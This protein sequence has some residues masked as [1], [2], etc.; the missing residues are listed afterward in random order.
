MINMA[1][2]GV[3]YMGKGLKSREEVLY[4]SVLLA[5]AA[6]EVYPLSMIDGQLLCLNEQPTWL[7]RSIAAEDTTI[8]RF[9]PGG[10]RGIHRISAQTIELDMIFFNATS[11]MMRDEEDLKPTYDV[12]PDTIPTTQPMKYTEVGSRDTRPDGDLDR[13]RRQFLAA[14]IINGID[15]TARLWKQLKRDVVQPNYNTGHF[16]DLQPSVALRVPAQALMEHLSTSTTLDA[17]STTCFDVEDAQLFLTWLTDPRSMYYISYSI[18]RMQ[19]T[20]DGRQALMTAMYINEHFN[21]GPFEELQ[22]A[23]PTDLLDATCIPQRIWI[24]RPI[25]GGGD[26]GDVVRWRIV[27]KALLLGEPDLIEE[28]L[29]NGHRENAV[30]TLKGRTVVGG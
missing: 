5:L 28:A 2:L 4:L 29:I 14:C 10:V 1:G 24:L 8:P 17:A 27:A 12:F 7:A 16:K 18:V 25:K 6:G 23:V 15:F 3:A 26:E 9:R 13:P 19:C 22:A 11:R 20:I 30:V 21:K